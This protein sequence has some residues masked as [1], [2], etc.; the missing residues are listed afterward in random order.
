MS[1]E[2]DVGELFPAPA[3]PRN[4]RSS[5]RPG[6]P[7]IPWYPVGH[8]ALAVVTAAVAW[9]GLPVGVQDV[10]PAV[11]AGATTVSAVVSLFVWA[12]FGPLASVAVTVVAGLLS[13]GAGTLAL[14]APVGV[15]V[16][17]IAVV[18]GRALARR[19]DGE[20]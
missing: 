6:L 3:R 5:R 16:L 8:L 11:R 7:A 13:F 14:Y 12:R 1:D 18:A 17:A 20:P 15:A 9:A 10:A 19:R 4:R 2:F